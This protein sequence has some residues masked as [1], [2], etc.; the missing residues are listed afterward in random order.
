M[1]PE[2]IMR[3]ETSRY[4]SQNVSIMA[5]D[6]LC[7]CIESISSS[8]SSMYPLTYLLQ[9]ARS[10]CAMLSVLDRKWPQRLECFPSFLFVSFLSSRVWKV[11]VASLLKSNKLSPIQPS[12]EQTDDRGRLALINKANRVGLSSGPAVSKLSDTSRKALNVIKKPHLL[13]PQ[14]PHLGGIYLEVSL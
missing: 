4:F 9:L 10:H 7:T 5:F 13:G 6:G 1:S 2:L 14:I 3:Q 12:P 11:R 8:R